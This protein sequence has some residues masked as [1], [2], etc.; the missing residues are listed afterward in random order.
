MPARISI[1]GTVLTAL[2]V[3]S[4]A[5]AQIVQSFQFGVGTFGPR[6][7]DSRADG[8][9]LRRDLFGQPLGADNSL[10]D[11][12]AFDIHD[13]RTGHVFGEWNVAF[14]NHL[15]VAGDVGFSRQSVFSTYADV[16][17]QNGRD[18][19]QTLRLQMVPMTAIVRFLPFGRPGDVQPYVGAGV[20]AVYYRYSEFGSFVDPDTLVISNARYTTTGTAPATVLLGG[21]RFPLGGDI[22]ALSLE[23]RYQ[24]AVGNTGGLANGFLDDKIDL[25]GGYFNVGFQIRF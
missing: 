21:V 10:T 25:G 19:N 24:W 20:G 14:G 1:L 7:I 15:E 8:D 6:G 5:S 11:S 22:Y 23:G 9:V 2:L 18:I 12:L 3:A 13:F 16:V 4:P 17:D